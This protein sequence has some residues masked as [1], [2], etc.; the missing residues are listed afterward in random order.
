ML[1]TILEPNFKHLDERGTLVQLVREG[2]KQFNVVE[3]K[4]MSVRGGHYHK[5]NNEVFYVISGGFEFT[6]VKG[7]VKEIYT[8]KA[9]DMFLVP[10]FVVHGFDYTQDTLLVGMYDKGVEHTDGTKDI[11]TA[12]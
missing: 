9:G 4:A 3:S 8:F 5:E 11:Y 1:I 2:Y 12:E 6:A 7:E 10:P